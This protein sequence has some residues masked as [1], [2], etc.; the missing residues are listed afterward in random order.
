VLLY[1]LL[2]GTTPLDGK[3]L[4]Q[5]GYAEMQRLIR[6]EEAPR[7]ST[8]LSSLG[9]QATSLANNRGT[10]P[11]RLAQLLHSDLDW[12]VM[13]ALEKDR[14]RRYGSPSNF[15]ADVERYLR[16][17]AIE[18]RPPSA[19]YKLRKLCQ[20]NKAA[21]VTT[22]VVAAALVLGTVLS[23]WQAVRATR[24]R[25]EKEQARQAEAMQRQEAESQRDR[26]TKAETEAKEQAAIAKAVNDFLT[27]DLLEQAS[28]GQQA[29]WN[30]KPDPDVKLRTVLDR[31]GRAIEGKFRDQPLVEASIRSTIGWTYKDLGQLPAAQLH[32]ERALELYRRERGEVDKRTLFML[33]RLAGLYVMQGKYAQAERT[34]RGGLETARRELGDDHSTTMNFMLR[35]AYARFEQG[36]YAAAEQLSSQVLSARRRLLGEEHSSTIGTMTLLG[37]IYLEQGKF[38]EA[39]TILIRV[40]E[41]HRRPGA[42]R[43]MS[44]WSWSAAARALAFLYSTQGQYARAERLFLEALEVVR[45]FQGEESGEHVHTMMQLGE[46]YRRQHKNDQAEKLLSKALELGQRVF[47]EAHWMT[48]RSRESLAT[49]YLEQ[50]KYAEA[51]AL[52][53]EGLRIREGV[54]DLPEN[55]SMPWR[56]GVVQSLLGGTLLG[57]KKYAESEPLLLAGYEKIKASEQAIPLWDRMTWL[58]EALERLVQLYDATGQK[59]KADAW[60]RKLEQAKVPPQVMASRA[61]LSR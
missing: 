36:D 27:E 21:V 8:R 6:E 28:L 51:E 16:H 56:L 14:N 11:K 32:T 22:A 7:P 4:R 44:K 15:A 34:G 1:E 58:P 52:L 30:P 43:S 9:A 61:V 25:N 19:T 29:G 17:D 53:R 48:L 20:R 47:G 38:A 10:D 12:I 46:M 49:V 2:T 18:A 45:G 59:D 35:L 50:G 39:E 37:N 33:D 55:S 31:A 60:R 26:A 40:Y 54:K 24:E 5:A 3:R 23:T 13:K 42:N 41:L 57:Q